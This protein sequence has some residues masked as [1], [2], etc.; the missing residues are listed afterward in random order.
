MP[1]QSVITDRRKKFQLAFAVA[2]FASIFLSGCFDSYGVRQLELEKADLEALAE[3]TELQIQTIEKKNAGLR[4]RT[5]EPLAIRNWIEANLKDRIEVQKRISE[6]EE[7]L[8]DSVAVLELCQEKFKT[9]SSLKI[10]TVYEAITLKNGRHY[11]KVTVTAFDGQ[12]LTLTHS[13]GIVGVTV[14]ELPDLMAQFFVI[15]PS[16]R[17]DIK[18]LQAVRDRKPE[19]LVT[20]SE[21]GARAA[22]QR[23]AD[24][25]A[26]ETSRAIA[27]AEY[28]SS[29]AQMDAENETNT[30]NAIKREV[31]RKKIYD[32]IS[33]LTQTRG[34]IIRRKSDL[35]SQF[36]QRKVP[37]AA[38][39][40]S[41]QLKA[42][43]DKSA[44]IDN[45]IRA[46]ERELSEL[47]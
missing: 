38:Q 3:R 15:P 43:D 6:L 29:R 41:R 37:L 1:N 10:G 31:S 32:Q 21:L 11:E 35:Q 36:S 12:K 28:E 7:Q 33:K 34:D 44:S 23:E 20:A 25:T 16:G 47:D 27:R 30:Q 24:D 46:L 2:I 8:S 22:R 14:A 26:T 13:G 42:F 18:A 9:K 4:G 39:D 5:E 17:I 19:S 40:Q 45:A